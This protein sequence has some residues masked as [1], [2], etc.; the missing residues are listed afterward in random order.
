[1]RLRRLRYVLD[2]PC[3]TLIR[4]LGE[5][6]APGRRRPPWRRVDEW[7]KALPARRW[8]KLR[9]GDGAKGPKVVRVAEAWVQT[10]DEDG[11]AGPRE[12]WGV[13][14]TVDQE[15]RTW[16]TLSNAPAE[17]PLAKAAAVHGRRHGAEEWYGAGKGEIGLGHYELR[18]W[19]GWHHHMTL[20]L[21][22]LW[23]LQL[24]QERWGEK[25]PALTV[26]Q[27]REIFS[28]LLQVRPPSAATI[29][30]EVRRVLR[31]NEETRINHWYAKTGRFPP[32]RRKPDG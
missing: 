17:V 32:P 11:R 29:A 12:R 24:H 2:V 15:P 30:A 27:L 19:V 10:K 23:F 13:I 21:L 4:D 28:Q 20:S 1:L 8:R 26:P 31:R 7:A 16:Y 18:S 3:N 5:V 22:A 9:L 6:P 25:I 14:R